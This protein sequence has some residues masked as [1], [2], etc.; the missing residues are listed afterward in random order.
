MKKKD[1]VTIK[2]L[3]GQW[4]KLTLNT[5]KNTDSQMIFS[6]SDCS[7]LI[8]RH[9][10]K[11]HGDVRLFVEILRLRHAA[12]LL[13]IKI[14]H[15]IQW[16]ATNDIAIVGILHWHLHSILVIGKYRLV[17]LRSVFLKISKS[18]VLM[19]GIWLPL[20]FSS[21]RKRQ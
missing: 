6:F 16:L 11:L 4:L 17:G 13:R 3:K 8:L 2:Y 15:L 18:G 7:W 1:L 9:L 19:L 20:G 10:V 21:R 14:E 12:I 5:F